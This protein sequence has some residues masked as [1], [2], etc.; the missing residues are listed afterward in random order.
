MRVEVVLQANHCVV[1]EPEWSHVVLV[2]ARQTCIVIFV[3]DLRHHVSLEAKSDHLKPLLKSVP[4]RVRGLLVPSE[5]FVQVILHELT[6]ESSLLPVEGRQLH[7]QVLLPFQALS[8][9][10]LLLPLFI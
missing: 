10:N 9:L 2:E 8:L 3:D 6:A 5:A 4:L 7:L 1:C